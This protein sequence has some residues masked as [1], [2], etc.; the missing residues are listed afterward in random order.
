MLSDSPSVCSLLAS[1]YSSMTTAKPSC[2]LQYKQDK[3]VSS[4]SLSLM[5]V[6]VGPVFRGSR[7][8]AACL[9]FHVTAHT[10]LN[11]SIPCITRRTCLS[12]MC[13][14]NPEGPACTG[15]SACQ[16]RQPPQCHLLASTTMARTHTHTHTAKQ[17]RALK[18]TGKSVSSVCMSLCSGAEILGCRMCMSF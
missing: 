10:L 16:H 18:Y 2:P 3:S 5:E 6:W 12:V 8:F 11:H 9:P 7:L 15:C 4:V 13:V 17:S 14:S 1:P